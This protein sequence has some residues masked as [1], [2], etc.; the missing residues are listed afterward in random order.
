MGKFALVM[1]VAFLFVLSLFAYVNNESTTLAVPFGKTYEIPKIVLVL[2]ACL[3]GAVMMLVAFAVR[4]T[5]RFVENYQHQKRQKKEGK[6]HGLYSKALN[7]ILAGDEK[8]A[9][10]ALEE[11]LKESPDHKDSLLR[12][13]DIFFGEGDHGQA[14]SFYKK[15]LSASPGDFEALFSL[16]RSMEATGRLPEA[17]SCI[18]EILDTDSDNLSAL[19][20]KRAILEKKGRWEDVID[21]QKTIIKHEQTE[22]ERGREQGNLLGYRYEFARD[23]L[24]NGDRE[25]AGKEFRN[26]LKLDKNFVP[27]YL[28][29]AEAMLGEG[30]AEDAADFLERGYEQTSLPIIL[31][32]LEDLLINL[33]DPP[34]IIKTY[35]NALSARPADNT[36]KFFLGKLYYRLEM[37]ED[38]FDVLKAV[39]TAEPFPGLHHLLGEL[40]LRR[41]ECERAVAEFKKTFEMKKALRVP[42]SC[43]SCGYRAQEWSGR[44]PNCKNWNTYDFIRN[45]SSRA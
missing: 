15:A 20:K 14:V 24:E 32:R 1:I 45:G 16:E 44:C 38:A 35:K 10:G 21:V 39:E 40:H 12:L 34:R 19:Y 30:E 3:F 28:G 42:Y 8:E 26:I 43:S 4:D 23:C 5:K 6:I 33:G 22:R 2:F 27:A 29:A 31:A 9:K 36:L 11:I 37:I 25:K 41:R 18:E 7:A 17:L 13:G